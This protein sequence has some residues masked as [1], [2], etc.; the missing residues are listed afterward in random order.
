[1]VTIPIY[2]FRLIAEMNY[3]STFDA[4]SDID[5]TIYINN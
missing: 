3:F 1:M 2:Y 4:T 5:F